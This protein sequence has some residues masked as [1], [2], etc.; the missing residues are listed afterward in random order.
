MCIS[1]WDLKHPPMRPA[2]Q[3]FSP[4]SWMISSTEALSNIAKCRITNRSC[5]L[6][7]S[8]MVRSNYPTYPFT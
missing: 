4:S 1:G 8:K 3:L 2:P 6:A 7:T 5:S